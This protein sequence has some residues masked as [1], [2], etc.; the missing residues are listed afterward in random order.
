MNAASIDVAARR[1]ALA[2]G[3]LA[4]LALV[5]YLAAVRPILR[6]ADWLDRNSGR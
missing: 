2:L 4:G 6:A 5:A 3:T 1:L